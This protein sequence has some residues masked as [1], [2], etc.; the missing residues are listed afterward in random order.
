MTSTASTTDRQRIEIIDLLRGLVIVLMALDH[1]RDYFHVAAFQ[2]DPLDHEQTTVSI[3]ATRWITHLCAPTFVFLS[4]VSA[5]L[6]FNRNNDRAGMSRFLL[7]RGAWL[8]VLEMTILSFGWSFAIPYT[9]FLQVIWAIGWSMLALAGLIWLPRRAVLLVGLAI[10]GAHNLLDSITPDQFGA[11]GVLWEFLHEGGVI[12]DAND[13]PIATLSYPI[14]PWIGIIA[15]GFGMGSLF[16]KPPSDRNERLFLTG[17][18]MVS[19]FILLRATNLYGD[20][21]PWAAQQD[22]MASTMTFLNVAKYPPSLQFVLVTLGLVFMLTPL[23]D[24]LRGWPA[25]A[26][27]VFGAVPLFFYVLHVYLVHALSVAAH[28]AAGRD[29]SGLI[30]YLRNAF[31]AFERFHETGFSLVWTY[32]AWITVLVL[33]YPAC[34][35]WAG[36]KARNPRLWWL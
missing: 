36:V 23:L 4:G 11:A 22:A 19:L 14:L 20:P 17:L 28:G 6:K 12:N 29:V 8:I 32:V 15:F 9:M 27:S 10:I 5:F 13:V 30:G 33:L 7:M 24:K 1:V 34:V 26:L 31:V 2:F 35:W 16:L 21:T 18:G 3:Y 25:R